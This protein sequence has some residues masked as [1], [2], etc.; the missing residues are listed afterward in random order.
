MCEIAFIVLGIL[1]LCGVLGGWGLGLGVLITV[2][3]H[4]ISQV[5]LKILD[6]Q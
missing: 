5:I 6:K 3:V 2:G 4:I 1:G